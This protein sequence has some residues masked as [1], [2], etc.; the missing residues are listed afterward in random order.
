MCRPRWKLLA[1]HK[2]AMSPQWWKPNMATAAAVPGFT[3]A[4]AAEA[5]AK[6][7]GAMST[8]SSLGNGEAPR[9]PWM[10]K[11]DWIR[12]QFEFQETPVPMACA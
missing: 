12:E 9:F 6:F 2:A 10:K 5:A 1:A 11:T 7:A 8:A 3:T 4:N